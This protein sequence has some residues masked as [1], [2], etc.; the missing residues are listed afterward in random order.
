[1]DFTIAYPLLLRSGKLE[2]FTSSEFHPTLGAKHMAT[3]RVEKLKD[4]IDELESENDALQDQ[5]DSISDIISG[6]DE[7][8]EGED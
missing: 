6:E 4:R 5:I 1:V 3:D 7:G 2:N 8:D